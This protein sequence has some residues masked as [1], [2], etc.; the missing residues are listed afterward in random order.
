MQ[1]VADLLVACFVFLLFL[2]VYRKKSTAVVRFWMAG[3]FFVVLHF[4]SLVFHPQDAAVQTLQSVMA[5][6]TLVL[7]GVCFVLSDPECQ[8]RPRSHRILVAMSLGTPWLL[9]VSFA[10]LEKPWLRLTT[11]L[12]YVGC[13]AVLALS[14]TLFRRRPL[15]LS[16]AVVLALGCGWW[17]SASLPVSDPSV[18]ICVVLTQCF[19]LNAVLLSARSRPLS[20]GS[21]TIS[22]G[23][24]AWGG[25][26]VVGTLVDKIW[27]GN[28]I[29][30]E[31]W[32][33]PKYFVAAGMVLRLLEDE[34]RSAE[35]ASEEYRLLFAG[36]PHPMWI[37]DSETLAFLDV[38]QAAV[39]HYGYRAEEFRSLRLPDVM[40]SETTEAL[41]RSLQLREPQQLAGPLRHLRK[42]G[43]EV[44][45]DVASQPIVMDGR[46]V[47]IALMQE[48]TERQRLHEQLI[49]QAHHDVL[50]GLPNRALFEQR[51]DITLQRA[52]AT[53]QNAAVF[54]IDLDRFKQINDSYGH[55]AGDLCLRQLATRVSAMI[56]GRDTF[57]RT[58]GDEFMLTLGELSRPE[59][60]E[61]FAATLLEVLKEPV[62]LQSGE[63]EP[64][65]SV[66][67]AVYPDDGT[68]SAQLWRDA[69]AAMYRAKRAGGNQWIRVS[70]E[71]SNSAAEANEIEVSLRRALKS[72][73]FEVH[74]QPQMTMDGE[75]HCLEALV[76]SPEP[77]LCRTSP[78]RFIAI[79]EES[80]LIVP[81]GDWVLEEVCRQIQEWRDAGLAPV[82]VAVNVSPL[83]L[84][85]FDF[86][87]KVASTLERYKLSARMLE[88]EVTEST[89]MPDRCDAPHQIS[90]LARMG[91]RFS[92]D[93]FGTGYSS[94]G[95]LHQLPVDSLKIDCSFTRRIADRKGTY[96]TVQAIIALAH[97]L[98]MKVV[99]EGVEEEEQFRILK[100]LNCDRV[101]GYLFSHPLPGVAATALL[102][103]AEG[104]FRQEI[105][106]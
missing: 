16:A 77:L 84:T 106:A 96:P 60:A 79:A 37:Y 64:G 30:P 89:V 22:M 1:N 59:D 81:L 75:L 9:A 42:D 10:A 32:N 36:N 41:V 2:S 102:R 29:N 50:T 83:Q 62:L 80:G 25:V 28:A 87:R 65:A 6:S 24:V 15:V 34:I 19:G 85:R 49:R 18:L 56:S 17:L 39:H 86:S 70:Q 92:V 95:R 71:I 8:K 103:R 61:S 88:F 44:Q 48:V 13:L 51:L 91:V 73:D 55:G 94:L 82:Q 5:L 33:L 78:E 27:P 26:W 54:C 98:G 14:F 76:R 43:T 100:S 21:A 53:G 11:G 97:T 66:G 105:V 63:V 20:A 31:V 3:W 69:D 104:A 101:Q 45:V 23:A 38:N 12:A 93:D 35:L 47:T 40:G 52:A 46:P 90:M 7:C 72:G 74:Y 68:E 58:G 99:A 4:V 67:F 57:A